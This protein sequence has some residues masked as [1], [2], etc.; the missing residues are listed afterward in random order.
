MSA[1]AALHG[2]NKVMVNLT[3]HIALYMAVLVKFLYPLRLMMS[4]ALSAMTGGWLPAEF[5]V[6]EVAHATH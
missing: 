3:T 6:S 1:A 4:G 5:L 2:D